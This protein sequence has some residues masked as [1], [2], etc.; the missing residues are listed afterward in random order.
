MVDVASL[1][2]LSYAIAAIPAKVNI[3]SSQCQLLADRVVALAGHL[4]RMCGVE[5]QEKLEKSHEVSISKAT[6]S[7]SVGGHLTPSPRNA[8]STQ[9]HHLLRGSPRAALP[10]VHV[11]DS[12]KHPIEEK[13]PKSP[14]AAAAV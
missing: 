2:T 13:E 6:Y 8:L 10:R 4:E 5:M 7:K 12:L 14:L 11:Y 9:R 1:I 3:N